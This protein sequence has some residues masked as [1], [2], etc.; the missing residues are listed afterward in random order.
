MGY[1]ACMF[2]T[3]LGVIQIIRDTLRG[4]GRQSVT[5]TSLLFEMP[6]QRLLEEKKTL[7][8]GSTVSARL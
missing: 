3:I 5:K 7:L 1:K 2:L 4:G 6:F 8:S